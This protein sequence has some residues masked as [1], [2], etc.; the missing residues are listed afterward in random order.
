MQSTFKAV[1]NNKKTNPPVFKCS[2]T[3]D[4]GQSLSHKRIYKKAKDP[5]PLGKTSKQNTKYFQV[6]YLSDWFCKFQ[7]QA[8]QKV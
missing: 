1:C 6:H 8:V 4:S 3:K 7:I 5:K 2:L